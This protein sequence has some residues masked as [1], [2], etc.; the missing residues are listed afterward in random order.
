MGGSVKLTPSIRVLFLCVGNSARSQMAEGWARALSPRWMEFFSAGTCP[1]RQVDPRAV[2]VM[3]EK[4]ID[5][6]RGSPKSFTAVPKPIDVIVAVC[7]QAECPTPQAGTRVERWELAD[8]AQVFGT[9]DMALERFRETRDE[10]E[11]RVRQ[12]IRALVVRAE[13]DVARHY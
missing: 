4:G 3:G 6:G 2:A 10:I 1:S 9:E 13:T 7:G 12:L 8:P 5:I 11:R